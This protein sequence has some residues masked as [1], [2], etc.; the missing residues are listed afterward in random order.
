VNYEELLEARKAGKPQATRMSVGSY[1]R[2][3]V[4]GKWRGVVDVRQ[5]LNQNIAFASGLR[6]ECVENVTLAS[7]HQVH[8][9]AVTNGNGDIV[10]LVLEPGIYQ[11]MQQLLSENPA[12]VAD[13]QFIN[14][15]LKSLVDITTYLHSRGIRHLCF[16][17]RT[18]LARKG[19]HAAL[20]LNHGSYYQGISD[21][22]EFFGEDADFVAPEVL[23]HG[24]VDDRCDVY[25]IGKF[26]QSLFARGDMPLAYRR[27]LT[28][29]ASQKPED[30]YD[31]PADMLK[32]VNKGRDA[33]KTVMALVAAIVIAAVVMVAYFDAFPETSQ[34]EF[35]KPAP[36]QAIDDL[37][38]DGFDPS[39]LGVVSPDSLTEDE[40]ERQRDY[41]AK[42]E[43]IFR[44]R[45]EQEADK[46]LSKI[47]NK[48]Y[49]SNSEK[50]FMTESESTT[51][52]LMMLQR[53]L[54][55]EANLDPSRSQLVAS[56]II[57]KLT[58]QKK[59]EMGGTNSRAIQK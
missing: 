35:V 17:P 57:E 51:Q 8:F 4:D 16:S 9:S 22:R 2:E 54:G 40:K 10:R 44:K 11:P 19:D 24:T 56:E 23:D 3:Q 59:K 20:L 18:V 58:E 45:F 13:S 48:N 7:A 32:A 5:E 21:L 29:A 25:S 55:A 39:E 33:M 12:I 36:R 37:L 26:M 27:V 38:D 50:Q 31:T 15:T 53:D 43:A 6:R 41:D 42:A 52:E 1:Y 14:N 46:I 28:K 30:R 34:V 49:M 47:Y